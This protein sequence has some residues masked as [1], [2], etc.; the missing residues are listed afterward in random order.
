VDCGDDD[1]AAG[2]EVVLIGPQGD[3]RVTAD[4]LAARAGT[5]ARAIA[6]GIGTRVPREYVSAEGP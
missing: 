2:D 5:I 4:E 1:V 3:E 6:T